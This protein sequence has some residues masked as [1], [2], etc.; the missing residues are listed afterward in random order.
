MAVRVSPHWPA[1][2][3]GP[4]S[5]GRSR[6]EQRLRDNALLLSLA[7]QENFDPAV[8]AFRWFAE[9]LMAARNLA[10]PQAHQF[11]L[12]ELIREADLPMCAT[13]PS[14]RTSA[15]PMCAECA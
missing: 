5:Q 3:V 13:W 12:N 7:A 1:R 10:A 4:G 15:Y 14:A 8:P 2:P 9:A 11:A 6:D